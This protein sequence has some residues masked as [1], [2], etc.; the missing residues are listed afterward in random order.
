[1]VLISCNLDGLSKYNYVNAYK[2]CGLY[3][4]FF[5]YNVIVFESN[6]A[7]S[8]FFDPFY[9]SINFINFVLVLE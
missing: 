3:T 2:S 6:L 5:W 9:L 8:T 7:V 4:T 1:M